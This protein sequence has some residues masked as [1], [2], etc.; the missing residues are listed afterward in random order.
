MWV[1]QSLDLRLRLV[2]DG[3]AVGYLPES[4][5][6]AAGLTRELVPLT[7]LPF[8]AIAR[9]FG[10]IFSAR[11]ALSPAAAAFVKLG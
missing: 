10:L 3:R 5:V 4:T 8:G 2:A 7:A 9:N 1:V 11:R 6:R